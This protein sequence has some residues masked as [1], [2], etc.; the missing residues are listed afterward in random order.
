MA[1]LGIPW[2]STKM[3]KKLGGGGGGGAKNLIRSG[4]LKHTIFILCHLY[5]MSLFVHL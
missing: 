5:L 2:K 3:L 4:N 1:E